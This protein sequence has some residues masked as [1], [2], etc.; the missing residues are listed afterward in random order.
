MIL[1]TGSIQNECSVAELAGCWQ[2]DG[3]NT[4]VSRCPP[5]LSNLSPR[6][7]AFTLIELLVVIAIIAI[8]AAMLL[9]A[10]AKAK[11]KAQQTSCLNNF[12]QQALGTHM[13]TDDFNDRLPPGNSVWGLNFGQMAGYSDLRAVLVAGINNNRGLLIFY[14]N[15]YIG[16]PDSSTATNAAGI[17]I[18]PGALGYTPQ[19]NPIPDN[20]FRQFYGAYNPT[21]ANTNDTQMAFFPFGDFLGQANTGPSKKLSSFNGLGSV[22]K[23]WAVSDLDLVGYTGYAG[24][25]NYSANAGPSWKGVNPPTPIHGRVRNYFYFDGHAGSKPVVTTG[26]YSGKF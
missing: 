4:I 10:L 2:S 22:D 17:M 20:A 11:Q 21:Y 16:L 14:I 5:D 24:Q 15:R 3:M 9:P 26:A 25:P 6:R 1:K 23:L 8:L 19:V 12:K 18:C 7:N 13:Y